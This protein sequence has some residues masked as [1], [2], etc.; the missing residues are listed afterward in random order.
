MTTIAKIIVTLFVTALCCSC[1]IAFD[2]I[3]GEGEVIRKE[4]TINE[5]FDTIKSSRGLDVVLTNKKDRKVII[6]ANENL[7]QHIEVYVEGE[8]LYITSD[9]NIYQADEKT[10]YVSY[11]KL[12]KISATSGSRVTSQGTVVQKDLAI[13]GTSGANIELK[14]KAETLTTSVTSGAI[15]DLSGKV[16]N[17][18]ASATS[19]ANIRANDLLSLVSNAKATSGAMIKIHAKDEFT[20]KATSGADVVYYGN[21]EKVSE[22]DNSGGNVRRN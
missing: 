15:M 1:N 12:G 10:V 14:V 17:H 6:E 11:N 21:P 13:S 22:N 16:N 8:T 9:K 19:G 4:K 20:G 18:K 2:G 3:R 5:N 7:H